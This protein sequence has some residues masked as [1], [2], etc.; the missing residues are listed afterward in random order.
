MISTNKIFLF[1]Q[2]KKI[3]KHLIF[4]LTQYPLSKTLID[5]RTDLSVFYNFL[6]KGWTNKF[7]LQETW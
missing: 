3:K 5:T 6:T 2:D 4:Y 1:R 7:S